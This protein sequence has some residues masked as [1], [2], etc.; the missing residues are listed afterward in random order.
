MALKTLRAKMA[1]VL[2]T[3][4]RGKPLTPQQQKWNDLAL[5]VLSRVP[6]ELDEQE[7]AVA[8]QAPSVDLIF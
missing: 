4:M 2:A 6:V 7:G 3:Q 1:S 8:R 5:M